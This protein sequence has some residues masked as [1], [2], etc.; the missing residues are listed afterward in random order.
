MVIRF[1]NADSE[2]PVAR[3]DGAFHR[4]RVLMPR[5]VRS[6]V[7][8]LHAQ[9]RDPPAQTDTL[10]PESPDRPRVYSSQVGAP[11]VDRGRFPSDNSLPVAHGSFL[12]RSGKKLYVKGTTYGTFAPGPDGSQFPARSV[13]EQDLRMMAANGFNAVRTYTP[14]PEWLLDEAASLGMLVMVGIPWAQHVTFLDQ[15]MHRE[16]EAT[17]RSTVRAYAGHPGILCY[18]VGNEIPSP[19]VRWHGTRRTQSFIRRLYSAAKEEDPAALVTYVNYPTTEY[20]ELPFLDLLVF[21]VFLEQRLQLRKYLA[22]LH[23]LAR[24]RPL[25]LG[26]VG[27]DS[28]RNGTRAQADSLEWQIRTAFDSGCAGLFVFSW[29]DDWYRG[30]QAIEDWEFGLTSR[31]REP[32]PALE[33]VRRTLSAVPLP[34]GEDAPKVSVVICTYNGSETI[35][36]TLSRLQEVDYPDFEVIVVDDGSTD[37]TSEI[38]VGYPARL[39]RTANRGLSSARNTGLKQAE[40]EIVV[41]LDDDAYPDPHW[42]RYVVHA[43]KEA[44]WTCVGGP[45]LAPATDPPLAQAVA[46]SPGGPVHVLLSDQ[47]AEH[48]PGCNMAF[49]RDRLREIGGF[50]P[51]FCTAGDDVDVCWRIQERGWKIGHHPGA[52][53]WHHRRPS[54]RRYLKQQV[55]YGRAEALLEDK[56]PGKYNVVGHVSWAGRIYGR[57]TAQALVRPQRVYHGLWGEAP[58]QSLYERAP[59]T[60]WAL[61]LMPEWYLIL[62]LLLPLVLLGLAWRPLLVVSTPILTLA[63]MASVA[64]AVKGAVRAS[65]PAGLGFL[66]KLRYRTTVGLLHLVQPAARLRGRLAQGL[67]IWRRRGL[68]GWSWL[69]VREGALWSERWHTPSAWVEALER[70]LAREGVPVLRPGPYEGWDL[71]VRGG[72]VGRVRLLTATEEH[73]QGRQLVRLRLSPSVRAL[74]VLLLTILAGF[75]TIP[76][77]GGTWL[78]SVLSFLASFFFLVRVMLDVG[79]AEA[80]VLDGLEKVAA[81]MGA[82]VMD[83]ESSH[84]RLPIEEQGGGGQTALATGYHMVAPSAPA[85]GQLSLGVGPPPSGADYPSSPDGARRTS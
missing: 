36:E 27:L 52:L 78:P 75:I 53:V 22:R 58:Y 73:G 33:T 56:W 8:A 32:K 57:G 14:P 69:G 11:P 15:R 64:Q 38:V 31:R 20:L 67:T 1:P 5:A 65:A 12:E 54:I 51:R 18:A 17:I 25:L 77:P 41:Y 3:R 34:P 45:N 16:I 66:G 43:F 29:T 84:A 19:I 74:P 59:G 48:V 35:A 70:C 44:D 79:C 62:G 82:L 49:R 4:S 72:V 10:Y 9:T 80:T 55:G 42:L 50:D 85:L 61:P 24:D 81:E 40:G 7:R 13:A 28:L 6:R 47:E 2:C 23:N 63:V 37:G 60:W 26:E 71:E 46:N 21:N 76:P 30:G 68:R 39:I 83:G